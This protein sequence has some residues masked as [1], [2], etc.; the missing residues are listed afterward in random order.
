VIFKVIGTPSEEDMSFVT[1]Q[2]AIEYLKSFSFIDRMDLSHKYPAAT[3]E[4][5][6]FLNQTLVLNPF[7]RISLDDA[8]K[9]PLFDKVRNKEAEHIQGHHVSLEFEKQLLDIQ[10]LRKLYIS[11]IS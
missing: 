7:F 6:D 9:H 11:E 8:I 3:S 4:A 10:S 2:K 5:I 1:D